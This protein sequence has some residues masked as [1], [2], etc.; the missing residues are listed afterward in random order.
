MNP[1]EFEEQDPIGSGQI[2][3]SLGL[4]LVGLY[5]KGQ[6]AS[7]P[8]EA[9]G[10]LVTVYEPKGLAANTS[11]AIAVPSHLTKPN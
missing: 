5:G 2:K 11:N 7:R 4:D 8:G 10:S 3:R 6:G 9:C 1:L